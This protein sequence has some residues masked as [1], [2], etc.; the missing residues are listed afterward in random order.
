[1]ADSL[2]LITASLEI[3]HSI[4]VR[5]MVFLRGQLYAMI[6]SSDE[7]LMSNSTVWR[8]ICQPNTTILTIVLQM[9]LTNGD[10]LQV[11]RKHLEGCVDLPWTN[12]FSKKSILVATAQPS[13]ETADG[14]TFQL[15]YLCVGESEQCF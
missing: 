9:N 15:G 6:D 4:T 7:E 2:N 8:I 14:S 13:N 3:F 11:K 1:M 5:P 10:Y 12:H